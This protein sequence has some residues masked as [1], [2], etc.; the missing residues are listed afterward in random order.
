MSGL[1][2][3]FVGVVILLLMAVF[4]GIWFWAW[5]PRHKETFD[6]LAAIPMQD[7]GRARGKYAQCNDGREPANRGE[8]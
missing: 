5:R 4:I 2:G 7:G 1:W 6:A 3:H 8:S